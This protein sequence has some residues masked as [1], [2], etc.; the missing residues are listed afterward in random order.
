MCLFCGGDLNFIYFFFILVKYQY[1]KNM[2]CS[3]K[4]DCEIY[5]FFFFSF[6]RLS[7]LLTMVTNII[8]FAYINPILIVTFVCDI[9]ILLSLTLASWGM[10]T[11]KIY[12]NAYILFT[13]AFTLF[14]TV[15][16]HQ[17]CMTA[18][19]QIIQYRIA[20]LHYSQCTLPLCANH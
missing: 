2:F 12:R 9:S 16:S 7:K 15:N 17:K 6:D 18:K 14:V 10:C 4:C 13:Y 5:V 1:K 3:N 8:I 11:D 19:P 20:M